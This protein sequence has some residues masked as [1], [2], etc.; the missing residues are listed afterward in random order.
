MNFDIAITFFDWIETR[1]NL[2][3]PED[4]M[5]R[6]DV[7]RATAYRYLAEFCRARRIDRVRGG[8]YGIDKYEPVEL[9]A[10]KRP[11]PAWLQCAS[12]MV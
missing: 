11:T 4:V 7:S 12:R 8:E 2:P 1:R 6:F 10:R 9:P 3:T 5:Q